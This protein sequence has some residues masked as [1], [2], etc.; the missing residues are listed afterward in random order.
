MKLRF[1]AAAAA[2]L[3]DLLTDI[4]RSSPHGTRRI[5]GRIRAILDLLLDQPRSGRLTDLGALRR[6]VVRPYPYLIFYE[7]RED[8]LIV[9][10]IRHGARSPSSMPGAT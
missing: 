10:G 7:I 1:T 5:Q 9:V 4:A 8:A 3:D 6:I 2:E